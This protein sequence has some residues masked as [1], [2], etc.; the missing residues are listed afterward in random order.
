MFRFRNMNTRQIT[1]VKGS[2]FRTIVLVKLPRFSECPI[3]HPL[4]WVQR[5]IV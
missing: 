1:V 5:E 2:E 3:T 4:F